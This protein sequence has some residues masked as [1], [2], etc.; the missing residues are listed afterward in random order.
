MVGR[1]K[2]RSRSRASGSG[3]CALKRP[4]GLGFLGRKQKVRWAKRIIVTPAAEVAPTLAIARSLFQDLGP[5]QLYALGR[6]GRPE[7]SL[8]LIPANGLTRRLPVPYPTAA[9]R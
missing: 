2:D 7:I 3:F 4:A 9:G 6:R 5:P 1:G 8:A